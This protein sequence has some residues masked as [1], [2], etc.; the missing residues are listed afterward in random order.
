MRATA[1]PRTGS[2]RTKI[3][4]GRFAIGWL[5]SAEKNWFD[6][7][8]KSSGAVSPAM[9]ATASST[10]VTIP[11][12]DARSV[13]FRIIRHFGVPSA[14]A[15]SRSAFGTSFS[16]FSVVRITIGI[17]S[18]ASAITPAQPL[19]WPDF[20]TTSAYTNSPTT[21]DG[22]D[23]RMSLMKRITLASQLFWPYSARYTPA[24]MPIGVPTNVASATSSRLPTIA[25]ARP[26]PAVFGGGVDSVKSASD[27]PPTPR[28]SVV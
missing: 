18:S 16:M 27:S 6:S 24:R 3:V 4:T 5:M 17:C 2:S 10:P 15:A 19:K 26:P 12:T 21:I 11:P 9:R 20:A 13:I 14:N 22:A 8:V 1:I 7:A 28:C 25:F 23:S